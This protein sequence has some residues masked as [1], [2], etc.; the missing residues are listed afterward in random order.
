M[1]SDISVNRYD[2]AKRYIGILHFLVRHHLHVY[3]KQA[4]YRLTDKSF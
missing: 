4:I 3:M 2:S 1:G